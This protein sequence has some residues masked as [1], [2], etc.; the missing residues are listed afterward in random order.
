MPVVEDAARDTA[1]DDVRENC[2]CFLEIE[3]GHTDDWPVGVMKENADEIRASVMAWRDGAATLGVSWA[4]RLLEL[5]VRYLGYRFFDPAW[6]MT[7]RVRRRRLEL[8]GRYDGHNR[9]D[10]MAGRSSPPVQFL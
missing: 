7:R 4:A 1:K 8:F 6:Q 9:R 2:F 5:V 10:S 3:T